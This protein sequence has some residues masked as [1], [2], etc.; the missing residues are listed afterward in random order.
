MGGISWAPNPVPV[1]GKTGV[2]G[3]GQLSPRGMAGDS[4]RV[5]AESRIRAFFFLRE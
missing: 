1:G 5:P 4:T 2:W 3:R